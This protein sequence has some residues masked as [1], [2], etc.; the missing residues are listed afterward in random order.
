VVLSLPEIGIN[1]SVS[2][3]VPVLSLP[4]IGINT[5]SV[6]WLVPVL[7]LPEIG[8]NTSSVSWLVPV[9]SLPEIGI[10]TLTVCASINL[11][12]P[13]WE[14][15]GSYKFRSH[16]GVWFLFVSCHSVQVICI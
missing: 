14:C 13:L 10:N 5:S 7:S 2:W 4:E 6:S 9:L 12:Q 1:T 3:L 16:K 11:E 15:S 8:I